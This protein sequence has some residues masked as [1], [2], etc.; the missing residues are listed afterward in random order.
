MPKL[1]HG[2]ATSHC[3]LQFLPLIFSLNVCKQMLVVTINIHFSSALF[4][5]LGKQ[6]A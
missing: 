5:T 6:K 3:I 2:L 4:I 1:D